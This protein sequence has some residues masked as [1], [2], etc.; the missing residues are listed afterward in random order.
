M[1]SRVAKAF[2]AQQ[3]SVDSPHKRRKIEVQSELDAT[4]DQHLRAGGS[5]AEAD[6]D[7]ELEQKLW[8]ELVLADSTGEE[9]PTHDIAPAV[10]GASSD[11]SSTTKARILKRIME[12][13]VEHPGTPEQVAIQVA[14]PQDPVETSTIPGEQKLDAMLERHFDM[15][16]NLEARRGSLELEWEKLVLAGSQDDP[17]TPTRDAVH[18]DAVN[19]EEKQEKPQRVFAAVLK[20]LNGRLGRTGQPKADM[21]EK[22]SKQQA[23]TTAR[24]E[25]STNP[26]DQIVVK[27]D[28]HDKENSTEETSTDASQQL[29]IFVKIDHF[30][31]ENNTEEPN[32]TIIGKHCQEANEATE[33]ELRWSPSRAR[34]AAAAPMS[35]TSALI[36]DRPVQQGKMEEK[37]LLQKLVDIL[38]K[39]NLVDLLHALKEALRK[40]KTSVVSACENV[41]TSFVGEPT[42]KTLV[43][44]GHGQ[45]Y[46]ESV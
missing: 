19:S 36:R 16:S 22:R 43:L 33:Q 24:C 11:C 10:P 3:A 21:D 38:H 39:V 4:L 17:S 15:P 34:R 31:K 28:N 44:P 6:G 2:G 42:R 29:E 14:I 40:V 23:F 45:Y 1:N 12:T 20:E 18:C 32:T 25:T 37:S 26:N 5:P 30:D 35:P 27:I 9:V 8:E 41:K 13:S 7:F 46:Y